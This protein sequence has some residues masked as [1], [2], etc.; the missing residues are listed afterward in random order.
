M[1]G[2]SHDSALIVLL[3]AVILLV[4]V[5]GALLVDHRKYSPMI[6]CWVMGWVVVLIIMR[7]VTLGYFG[8]ILG[9][10]TF[11]YVLGANVYY[12]KKGRRG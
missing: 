11:L 3:V 8:S 4:A 1:S 2:M 10:Y 9:V 12:G 7:P 6:A 5:E